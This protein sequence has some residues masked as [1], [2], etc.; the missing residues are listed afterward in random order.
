MNRRR[1]LFLEVA[2]LMIFCAFVSS[3]GAGELLPEGWIGGNIRDYDIGIDRKVVKQGKASASIRSKTKAPKGFGTIVQTCSAETFVG[4]RVRMSASVRAEKIDGWAGLWMRVDG[5][6]KDNYSL[7][8]DNMQTRPIR[9][10]VAWKRYEIVLDI[11]EN[12][13][14]MSFGILLS[15]AGQAWLDDFKFEVVTKDVPLTGTARHV[16]SRQPLSLDFEK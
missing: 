15:G 1:V 3:V 12:S 16:L 14:S 9:G 10:T 6:G 2:L 8:F 4:K 11:P 5:E 7:S 13:K